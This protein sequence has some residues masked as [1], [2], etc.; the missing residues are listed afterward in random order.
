HVLTDLGGELRDGLPDLP[1]QLGQ[2][3]L[4][5][6]ELGA[7]GVGERVHLAAALGG[8]ADQALL[9]QLGQPRADGARGRCVPPLEPLLQQP[10]PLVPV[11][12]GLLQ[13]DQQVEAEPAVTEHRGHHSTFPSTPTSSGSPGGRRS[14]A[15]APETVVTRSRSLPWPRVPV[16]RL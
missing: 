13:Q 4:A 10:A 6:D 15:T 14:S 1:L 9:L 12:R 16:S 5:V 2:L 11:P 7:P 3:L 8:V